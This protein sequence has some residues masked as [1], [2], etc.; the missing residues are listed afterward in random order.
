MCLSEYRLNVKHT[1]EKKY[2][3]T[4]EKIYFDSS[5]SAALYNCVQN[6][7]PVLLGYVDRQRGSAPL[8]LSFH[9]N[10]LGGMSML[11]SVD[12]LH[13]TPSA[14]LKNVGPRQPLSIS[15]LFNRPSLSMNSH[16]NIL[17]LPCVCRCE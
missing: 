16:S 1:F 9:C 15:Y 11:I 2:F 8:H 7:A 17:P 4:A 13:L 6:D 12:P 5:A 14:P 3:M 10:W